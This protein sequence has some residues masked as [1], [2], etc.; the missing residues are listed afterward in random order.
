MARHAPELV[1][2]MDRI[3]D[4]QG[5]PVEHGR[6]FLPRLGETMMSFALRGEC[7]PW[8]AED[9]AFAFRETFKA[10]PP[11]AQKAHDAIL[12][13]ACKRPPIVNTR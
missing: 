2:G 7:Q 5:S 1:A 6:L 9:T 11:D 10:A 4:S 3:L 8:G 13:Y 12:A